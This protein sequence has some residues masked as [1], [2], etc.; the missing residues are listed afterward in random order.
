MNCFEQ[1]L[2]DEKKALQL[3]LEENLRKT[4]AADFE[5]KLQLLENNNKDAEEKLKLSRQ[6]ELEFLKREQEVDGV[7]HVGILFQ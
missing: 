3:T 6:K 5:N 4:I 1:K 7:H 2:A